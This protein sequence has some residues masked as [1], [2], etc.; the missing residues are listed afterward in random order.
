ME[1]ENAGSFRRDF[2]E[3]CLHAGSWENAIVAKRS[4]AKPRDSMTV[5][6]RVVVAIAQ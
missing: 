2:R 6:G 4:Q 3:R 1:R 5:G